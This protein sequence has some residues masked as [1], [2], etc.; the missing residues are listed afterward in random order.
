VLAQLPIE[1]VV[2]HP[3]RH[4]GPDWM[5]HWAARAAGWQPCPQHGDAAEWALRSLQNWIPILWTWT[6]FPVPS[7]SS[8]PLQWTR[9]HQANK[10]INCELHLVPHNRVVIQVTQRE[11]S[12]ALH[13]MRR[14]LCR[15][16]QNHFVLS[17]PRS[18]ACVMCNLSWLLLSVLLLSA[19]VSP[20]TGKIMWFC[21]QSSL[22]LTA[23]WRV[24]MRDVSLKLT[25]IK[26]RAVFNWFHFCASRSN[27]CWT[28]CLLFFCPRV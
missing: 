25:L 21:S 23:I 17:N 13:C 7:A 26:S 27:S 9:G 11:L 19:L 18:R 4:V 6:V 28:T 16:F 2:P 10:W 3:W 15:Y 12:E 24:I 8:F 20:F 5:G 14:Y 1:A 22:V